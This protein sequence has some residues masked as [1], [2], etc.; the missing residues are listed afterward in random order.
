MDYP[1]GSN[2][3]TE[4]L[5]RGRLETQNQRRCDDKSRGETKREVKKDLKMLLA[6][7]MEEGATRQGMIDL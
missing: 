5:V 3:I 7:K 1:D 6:L 2:V 4:V